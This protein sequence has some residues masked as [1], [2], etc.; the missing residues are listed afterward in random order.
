VT[1]VMLLNGGVALELGLEAGHPE[2]AR[3]RAMM[4]GTGL[5]ASTVYERVTLPHGRI[6]LRTVEGRFLSCQPDL[7]A[8]YGLYTAATLGVREAFEEVLW[9]DGTVS[10]RSCDL[11]YVTAEHGRDRRVVVNRVEPGQESRFTYRHIPAVIP[12]QSRR[13]IASDRPSS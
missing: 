12:T 5:S 10:L 3:A 11:T 8:N 13:P 1:A 4:T 9:P 7:G 2:G 6:A